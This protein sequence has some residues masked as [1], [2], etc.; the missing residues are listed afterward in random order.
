[1][2][3]KKRRLLPKG[4]TQGMKEVSGDFLWGIWDAMS[5]GSPP[6]SKGWSRKPRKTKKEF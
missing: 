3:E 2:A 1:M 4:F 6:K 5:P